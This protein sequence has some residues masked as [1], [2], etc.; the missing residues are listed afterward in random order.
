MING[1]LRDFICGRGGAGAMKRLKKNARGQFVVIAALLI[2]LLTFSVALSVHQV[3]LHRQQLR[4]E[5][6]EELVLGLTSDLE[7][8][9]THALG[10]AS[11]E[12]NASGASDPVSADAEGKRFISKWTRSM[13]QSYSHLSMEVSPPTSL[14]YFD[15]GSRRI[16]EKVNQSQGLSW[17]Y[18][19]F[20]VD[21]VA[22]GFMGGIEWK[23]KLVNLKIEKPV[24]NTLRFRLFQDDEPIP[25]LTVDDLILNVLGN[26]G[27]VV[28][29]V[30]SLE[31][32]GA[33]NYIIT[34][35]PEILESIPGVELLVVTPEDQIYVQAS[36]GG[37]EERQATISL[38]GMGITPDISP[39]LGE[40][41]LG[42]TVYS[43]PNS[44]TTTIRA[45]YNRYILKYV[46]LNASYSFFNWTTTGDVL[47][48]N[49]TTSVTWVDV[50]GNGGIT[51]F[52]NFS[53]VVE[54]PL[55]GNYSIVLDSRDLF[56]TSQSLG[57]ITFNDTEFQL[58]YELIVPAGDYEIEYKPDGPYYV[59]LWWETTGNVI[60]WNSTGNPTRLEVMGNGTLTAIYTFS[61]G[62]WGTLYLDKLGPDALLLPP[63]LWSYHGGNPTLP[64]PPRSPSPNITIS[65]PPI[66]TTIT[67]AD[68]VNV[69]IYLRPEPA[70]KARNMTMTL[71][72]TINGNE[73]VAGS[74]TYTRV[75]TQWYDLQIV[76]SEIED[77]WAEFPVLPEG[78]MVNLQVIMYYDPPSSGTFHIIY[79]VNY[80]SRIELAQPP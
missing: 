23:E 34:F 72:F 59:F 63:H 11:Q 12:F 44:T 6:V 55:L 18:T 4:Y 25:N 74:E 14:F 73:Y 41:Q 37:W 27:W 26:D 54:P 35:T 1:T 46:P 60:P 67:L 43:L 2:A 40:I 57:T 52:Y 20:D 42:E 10:E 64:V 38:D 61:A 76:T 51:A 45:E 69:S 8:A 65:S 33:G 53:S 3:N 17:A 31:Y 29:T 15:W 13:L 47:V 75:R 39:D 36:Y 79:G 49:T 58:P 80:P 9:L 48:G 7:R 32:L 56:Y 22:Y 16:P 30:T 77:Q 71:S 66:P 21:I 19:L 70:R 62:W 78:T 5:P 28:A 24:Q 68:L 50:Y